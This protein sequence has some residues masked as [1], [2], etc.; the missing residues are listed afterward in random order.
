LV[1]L[2]VGV[3]ALGG[4]IAATLAK[5]GGDDGGAAAEVTEMEG[6]EGARSQF[7]GARR[8]RRAISLYATR[9]ATSSPCARCAAGSWC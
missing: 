7:K 3:L 8:H 9:T 6:V 4:A 2:V 1:L 5:Q